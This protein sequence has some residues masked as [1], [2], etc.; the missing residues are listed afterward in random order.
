MIKCPRCPGYIDDSNQDSVFYWCPFC[1]V[2]VKPVNDVNENDVEID[3]G[4]QT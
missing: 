4:K 1:G 3:D 2:E